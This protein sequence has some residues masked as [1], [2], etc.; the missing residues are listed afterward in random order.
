MANEIEFGPHGHVAFVSRFFTQVRRYKRL[1]FA[2]WWIVALP[3]ILSVGLQWLLIRR[4]LPTFASVGRMILSVKLSIPNANF[5]SEEL[6]NFFGTQVELMQSSSVT[7]RAV[8]RLRSEQPNLHSA[9][10]NIQISLSPKT[11]I[12][13]LIAVSTDQVYAQA[14]LEATMEEYINLK[15]DLLGNASTSTRSNLQEE[16]VRLAEELE[17]S[18]ESLLSYQA[19]NS[20]VF[21]Q[22][23]GENNAAQYFA[24]LIQ[25]LTERKSEL[26]LLKTLS[27][28]ENLERQQ[29]LFSQPGLTVASSVENFNS[30]QQ[31]AASS[32]S[33][34]IS[35]TQQN[36]DFNSGDNAS[37]LANTPPAEGGFEAGYLEVK[38][39]IVLLKAKRDEL[40]EY[41]RPKHPDIVSLNEE[42]ARQEKLL[43]VYQE[44]SQEQLKNRQHTLEVEIAGIEKQI[45]EWELKAVEVSKKLSDFE[46][47]KENNKRLQA[48]YDQLQATLQTFDVD[49]GIGQE[50]VSIFEPATPAL[51][52][53]KRL[54]RHLAMAGLIGLAFGSGILLLIKQLDDRP[55]SLSELKEL[56]HEP[57]LGQIP[58]LKARGKNNPLPILREEDDRHEFVEAFNNLR[59]ALVFKDS[60]D[61]HS[62]SIVVTSAT[63]VDGKSTISVNLAITLAHAGAR[64]LLV[65]ADLRCGK[66]HRRFSV[67]ETPGLAEVLSNA[68]PWSK[69]V[70]QTSVQNLDLLPRG[71]F[72]AQPASLLVKQSGKLLKE[73]G[74]HYDYYIFDTAPV[75]VTDDVLSLAPHISSVIMVIRA[76]STSGRV[77]KAALE[78]LYL[79]RVKVSGLVLNAVAPNMLEYNFYGYREYFKPRAI[80]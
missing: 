76:G 56:F 75:M 77:I 44:Q 3:A 6:N 64:V 5:Y 35:H 69:A 58:L 46:G 68:C 70:V 22:Q 11:T 47:L 71:A 32:Q 4:S 45:E 60:P 24:S 30:P 51:P 28:D 79:R 41:L 8:L 27:L 67:A 74:S 66:I 29:R 78:L 20:A 62:R 65:D 9:P 33:H 7:N 23:N 26:Q 39:Q 54:K 73:F 50:S 31:G 1:L 48:T 19:T 38:Q 61:N 42:I 17:K 52:A 2:Y 34:P 10:V 40:S 49:K 18:R 55:T 36:S 14:Y 53:P 16:R 63:P 21:L 59:S 37:N 80:A 25:Q 57:V 13:N 12:F 43:E 15:K 72:L